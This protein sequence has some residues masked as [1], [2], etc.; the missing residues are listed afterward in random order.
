MMDSAGCGF[1][2]HHARYEPDEWNKPEEP[3]PGVP[4]GKGKAG[5]K[6]EGKEEPQEVVSSVRGVGLS[7]LLSIFVRL[8]SSG[9]IVVMTHAIFSFK[10]VFYGQAGVVVC[11]RDA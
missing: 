8:V 3:A 4:R 5:E 7:S 1:R 10:L 11:S 9:M 2:E 6:Q